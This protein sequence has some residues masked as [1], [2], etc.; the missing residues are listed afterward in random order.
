MEYQNRPEYGCG[1]SFFLTYLKLKEESWTRDN[2]TNFT[3]CIKISLDRQ[4][5]NCY[6]ILWQH[7]M[8]EKFCEK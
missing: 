5:G 7:Q 2:A 1:A 8:L 6:D 3:K 4:V